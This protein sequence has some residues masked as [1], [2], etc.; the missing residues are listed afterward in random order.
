V[1][2]KTESPLNASDP[3]RFQ[4]SLLDHDCPRCFWGKL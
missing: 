4:D 2:N 3:V 1:G